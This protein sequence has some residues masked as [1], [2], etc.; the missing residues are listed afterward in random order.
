[1][2]AKAG[3]GHN[4]G[5]TEKQRHQ[6]GSNRN[7]KPRGK[8]VSS[9]M[10]VCTA[11]RKKGTNTLIEG[12]AP[13]ALCFL[14]VCPRAWGHCK[15]SVSPASPE[16]FQQPL[17]HTFQT[18]NFSS[19]IAPGELPEA[20]LGTLTTSA[21]KPSGGKL[22]RSLRTGSPQ[23]SLQTQIKDAPT[24]ERDRTVCF[25]YVQHHAEG[26]FPRETS[27]CGGRNVNL[28]RACKSIVE[29]KA[30]GEAG[31]H[32]GMCQ[33]FTCCETEAQECPPRETGHR[34]THTGQ[35]SRG[36][37]YKWHRRND[38]PEHTQCCYEHHGSPPSRGARNC[39]SACRTLPAV[40]WAVTPGGGLTSW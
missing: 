32:L 29:L 34:D 21:T 23:P 1:M 6:V 13:G 26:R 33:A 15:H 39:L 10:C 19:E 17:H 14:Q 24:R 12:P 28:A 22:P 9:S 40:T 11:W 3:Q 27:S 25:Y 5:E 36:Q 30:P 20:W 7:S 35:S 38:R 8:P 37:A 2:T 31:K 18:S 4:P 16:A